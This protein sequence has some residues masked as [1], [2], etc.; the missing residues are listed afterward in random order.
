MRRLAALTVVAVSFHVLMEWLF[1]VTK[2]S[3]LTPLPTNEKALIPWMASA[4]LLAAGLAFL[5]VLAA[6]ARTGPRAEK[7]CL[8]LARGVP[9]LVLAATLLLLIDNFTRTL[10][11]R[12]SASLEGAGKA[13]PLL[14]FA[15]LAFFSWRWLGSWMNGIAK[16]RIFQAAALILVLL[17]AGAALAN[18]AGTRAPDGLLRAPER[19]RT[20]PTSS[21][22]GATALTRTAPLSTATSATP[23]RSSPASP[24]RRWCSRTPSR[25]GPRRPRRPPR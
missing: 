3:F 14:L 16:S 23:P 10:F 18:T 9:A 2:P 25:T 24:G 15:L 12:G 4:P 8:L 1:F 5:L 11:G 20:G 7:V 13:V 21:S 19:P 22:W 6:V 17:S